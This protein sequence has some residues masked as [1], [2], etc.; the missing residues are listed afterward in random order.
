MEDLRR[1]YRRKH[2]GPWPRACWDTVVLGRSA[3]VSWSGV[4]SQVGAGIG[5]RQ[6]LPVRAS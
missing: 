6:G 4:A 2:S 1:S 3:G 5:G